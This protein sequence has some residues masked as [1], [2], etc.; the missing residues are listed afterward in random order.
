MHTARTESGS[1]CERT[2]R[3]GHS[4]NL[5]DSQ[6]NH[7]GFVQLRKS[8]FASCACLRSFDDLLMFAAAK[9]FLF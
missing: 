2:K 9:V 7:S 3:W 4:L 1:L 8:A 5:K 6:T